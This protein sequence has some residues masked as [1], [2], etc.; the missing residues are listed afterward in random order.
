MQL[1]VSSEPSLRFAYMTCIN[2]E[3]LNFGKVQGYSMEG[4]LSERTIEVRHQVSPLLLNILSYE[5]FS[6]LIFG[7]VQ[8][9]VLANKG[10]T[11]YPDGRTDRQKTTHRSPSCKLQRWAQK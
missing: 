6:S 10:P 1:N 3:N 4:I 8:T 9:D 7:L 2:Q 11:V 5:F